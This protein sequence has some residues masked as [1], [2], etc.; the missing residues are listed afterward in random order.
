M[1]L[2][3]SAKFVLKVFL[4]EI[5]TLATKKKKRSRNQHFFI[6]LYGEDI[7]SLAIIDELEKIDKNTCEYIVTRN[8]A[9]LCV[10]VIFYVHSLIV[11]KI[12]K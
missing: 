2:L 3:G 5:S 8:V 1:F 12:T 4:V 10:S 11:D 7:I 6:L 9:F